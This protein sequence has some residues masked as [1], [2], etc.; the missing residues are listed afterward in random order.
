MLG[1][2]MCHGPC[3]VPRHGF[4]G[5]ERGPFDDLAPVAFDWVPPDFGDHTHHFFPGDLFVFAASS[6]C[7]RLKLAV[8]FPNT[9]GLWP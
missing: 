2:I 3:A 7:P 1:K 5:D 8:I 9:S 6:F 4:A